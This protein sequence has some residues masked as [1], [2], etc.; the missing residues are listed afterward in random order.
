MIR[1]K[2]SDIVHC[3]DL[4]YMFLLM[5]KQVDISMMNGLMDVIC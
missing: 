4:E 1:L 2:K 5:E 3:T